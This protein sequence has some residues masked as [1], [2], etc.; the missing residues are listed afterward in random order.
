M[1]FLFIF[2]TP[3]L[4]EGFLK[5]RL[6]CGIPI[7]FTE[8]SWFVDFGERLKFQEFS[9]NFYK[10][11]I[12][13]LNFLFKIFI[14]IW[15]TWKSRKKLQK[16]FHSIQRMAQLENSWIFHEISKKYMKNKIEEKFMKKNQ[17]PKTNKKSCQKMNIF[18]HF[19]A[20]FW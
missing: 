16:N 17:N 13:F 1:V 11:S 20:F 14:K 3:L 10:F 19:L 12:F 9:R 6:N 4:L 7:I 8:F 15:K 5:W 18:L 2:F